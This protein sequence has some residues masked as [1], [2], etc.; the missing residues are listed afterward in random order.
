MIDNDS[1]T[2]KKILGI[3]QQNK[4]PGVNFRIENETVVCVWGTRELKR[5]PIPFFM[6]LE[7]HEITE[8][9]EREIINGSTR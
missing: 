6:A 4:I 3:W 8:I 2:Q 9:L 1:D 7:S 5:L